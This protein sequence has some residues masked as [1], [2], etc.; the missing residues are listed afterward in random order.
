MDWLAQAL[1]LLVFLL[2]DLGVKPFWPLVECPA[3]Y[4]CVWIEFVDVTWL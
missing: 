3:L 1:V 2:L 4:I